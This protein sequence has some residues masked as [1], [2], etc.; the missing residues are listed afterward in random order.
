MNVISRK[1][2]TEWV[3]IDAPCSG[4]LPM[5]EVLEP[6]TNNSSVGSGAPSVSAK[7]SIDSKYKRRRFNQSEDKSEES[8]Q[9]S[10]NLKNNSTE[11]PIQNLFPVSD[12]IFNQFG[13]YKPHG[14]KIYF[15]IIENSFDLLTNVSFA[16]ISVN[17][18]S[19]NAQ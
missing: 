10:D 2:S 6:S 11:H 8:E 7:A 5:Y 13:A 14:N 19:Y 16:F 4:W 9:I 12:L 15:F 1:L 17:L 18:W 3:L